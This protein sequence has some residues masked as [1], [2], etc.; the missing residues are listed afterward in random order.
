VATRGRK[1][2]QQYESLR[3]LPVVYSVLF[4]EM[5]VDL[6]ERQMVIKKIKETAKENRRDFQNQF[7]IIVLEAIK[8]LN[9]KS[10]K[11]I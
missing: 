6:N 10:D 3:K 11:I 8:G 1:L 7:A 4:K 9:E 2:G 5:Y